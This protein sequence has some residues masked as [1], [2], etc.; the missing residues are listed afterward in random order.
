MA[1]PKRRHSNTRS[2]TRRAHHFLKPRTVGKCPSCGVAILP[3]Q[4][5]SKCGFY[6]GK[7]VLTI[8]SKKKDAKKDSH[9]HDHSKGE[10]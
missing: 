1:N 10:E 5:C 2:R 8:K 9:G 3:H 6:R 4:V 7:Q